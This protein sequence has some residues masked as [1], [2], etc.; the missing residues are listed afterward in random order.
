[1]GSSSAI[2]DLNVFARQV[3][4]GLARRYSLSTI[5]D[6]T[7]E[8]ILYVWSKPQVWAE[9]EAYCQMEGDVDEDEAKH[10]HNRLR[11]I[12]RRAG[13]RYCRKELASAIGYSPE[14]E[15][16]YSIGQL[17]ILAEWYFRE[18]LTERG[19]RGGTGE[20]VS[21]TGD[22]AHGGNWL[23]S[24]LDVQRGL[25]RIPRKYRARLRTRFDHFG[26]YSDT[27][28]VAKVRNLATARG[29]RERIERHLGTS[30]SAIQSR[31][32]YALSKLQ[33]ALGGSSPYRKD[34]LEI[35]ATMRVA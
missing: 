2:D 31:V 22:P 32:S 17:R 6:I 7:Q 35:D 3:A 9:W 24:L 8:I 33:R 4:A 34:P 19:S 29:T 30:E 16:Y 21:S 27:E 28:L 13:E 1:M 18:G 11:L 10:T 5:D 26:Q 23:S 25:E 20:R 12:C 14:D 15:A